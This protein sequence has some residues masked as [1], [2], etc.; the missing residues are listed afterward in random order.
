MR[1]RHRAH[2]RHVS[3]GGA[4]RISAGGGARSGLA[5]HCRP[6]EPKRNTI[7]PRRVCVLLLCVCSDMV[8]LL[9]HDELL[10]EPTGHQQ[11]IGG[12][13]VPAR[14][15]HNEAEGR[16]CGCVRGRERNMKDGGRR[17]V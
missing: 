5:Q 9:E 17:S 1:T 8:V 13:V 14:V 15:D 11:V 4:G 7:T 12:R 16:A 6:A 10:H 3:T 2:T